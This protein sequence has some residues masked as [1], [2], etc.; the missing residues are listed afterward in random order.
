M[1]LL[2]IRHA[3]AEDRDEFAESGHDD[4]ERPLTRDGRRRMRRA[5]RGLRQIA[6]PINKIASS[7]YV[8]AFDTAQIVAKALGV[9][10]EIEVLDAL[11]P[12]QHGEAL[13]PWLA[14]QPQDSTVAVVGHEP[15]LG[16]LV[17]WLMTGSVESHVVFK[18]GGVCLLDLGVRPSGGSALLYWLLTPAHLRAI[19]D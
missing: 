10:A 18:K 15:H 11:T 16:R 3:I 12:E 17:T 19:A 9:D 14:S 5:A 4:S 13:I 1:Q 2:V 8:R 6:P 7:P